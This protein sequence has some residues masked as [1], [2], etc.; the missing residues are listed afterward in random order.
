M[1]TAYSV[2]I[3]L[4]LLDHVTPALGAIAIGLRS[5]DKDAKNTQVSIAGLQ[6]KLAGL[7][8]MAMAGG[9]LAGA[10]AVGLALFKGPLDEAKNFQSE[11]ARFTS[12]GF[13]AKVDADAVKFARGMKTY[14]TS[15]RDNMT[16]VSD[17][18][19]VFKNLH[20]AEVAAPI[21][22]KMK[23]AN[24]AVFGHHG[25]ANEG[26]FMDMLKVIEFRR[27]LS[28]TEEFE[29]QANFV[30]KV[31]SG[32]RNRVDATQL[33]S[34]LK[35]GGVALTGR[36]N[37]AFY[38]GAEPLIQEFGGQR[39]GTGSM[40]IYQNWV[41]GRGT[42][43]AQ[44]ELFRLGLL[45]PD[46]VQF[47]K[48]G[49]LKKA[50]PGS[51]IG[52]RVL[53]Q[54]GELAVLEKVVLP[55]FAKHGITSEEGVIRTLGTT[56]GNRT[57]SGLMS[58]IYQQRDT[59]KIQTQANEFA[60]GINQLDLTAQ[61]TLAGKQIELHKRWRD[62]MLELGNAVLPLAIKTVEGL[63]RGLQG[64]H[65][66]AIEFPTLTKALTVS[67]GALSG[68]VAAGGVFMLARAGLGALGLAVGPLGAAAGA[69]SLIGLAVAFGKVAIGVAAVYAAFEV[70]RG[71][72]KW[73]E[74][75]GKQE[76]WGR[77]GRAAGVRNP[78]DAATFSNR[79]WKPG[80]SPYVAGM[81]GGGPDTVNATINMDGRKVGGAIIDLMGRE[82]NRPQSGAATFDGRMNLAAP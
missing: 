76:T 46:L 25:K 68:L 58:R 48:L 69:A 19:A 30:Q 38:L 32:S 55:A 18:M 79:N 73:F 9:A 5:L 1:F 72:F 75:T 41:Q 16:L 7:K 61:Q 71:T 65:R 37:A 3:R 82:M 36:T 66:F 63:T 14:G 11:V 34:A 26:K 57:G 15:A 81:R 28:S 78:G 4:R 54:E 33:L 13:G 56:L 45:N 24:E 29:T 67:F 20:H 77:E 52:S 60:Q 47:N 44:Q 8:G 12:L 21:L 70:L 35:T 74:S 10:G 42:L 62:V 6:Q 43:T 22:A 59:L 50:L 53:E 39:Y 27:G 49:V 2:A 40:S 31:I 80:T 64:V 23:F 51:F 17:A